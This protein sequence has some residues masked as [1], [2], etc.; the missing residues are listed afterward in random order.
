MMLCSNLHPSISMKIVVVGSRGHHPL[1]VHPITIE[2]KR[3]YGPLLK[4]VNTHM[5]H[6]SC[7]RQ[8]LNK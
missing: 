2:W 1:Q 5:L 3:C 4:I 6:K 7:L 8:R